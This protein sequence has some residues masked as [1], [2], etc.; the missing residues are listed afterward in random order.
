MVV[1]QAQEPEARSREPA[2]GGR[3]GTSTS[4]S[5]VSFSGEVWKVH[6]LTLLLKVYAPCGGAIEQKATSLILLLACLLV[7]LT[8]IVLL[9]SFQFQSISAFEMW[10][11]GLAEMPDSS[12]RK[13]GK[14][15]PW[16]LTSTLLYTA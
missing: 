7:L 4:I 16:K 12:P 15:I 3:T 8:K 2:R 13:E 1:T 14:R 6:L 10:A 5:G 11:F 9:V